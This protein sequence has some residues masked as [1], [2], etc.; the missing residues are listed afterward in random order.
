MRQ[1]VLDLQEEIEDLGDRADLERTCA[2][3]EGKLVVT[4]SDPAPQPFD[5]LVARGQTVLLALIGWENRIFR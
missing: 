1:N 3:F 4:N 2:A 5:P